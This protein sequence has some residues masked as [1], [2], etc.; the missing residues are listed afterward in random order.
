MQTQSGTTTADCLSHSQMQPQTAPSVWFSPTHKHTQTN[1][2]KWYEV[3]VFGGR[4]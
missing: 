2:H 3:F 1:T 4:N